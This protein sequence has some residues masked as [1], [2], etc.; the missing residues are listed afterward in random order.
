MPRKPRRS[1]PERFARDFTIL[2]L[3]EALAVGRS[4]SCR[5][6]K[7]VGWTEQVLRNS[8]GEIGRVA[9]AVAS[10]L[11]W[12]VYGAAILDSER[13]RCEKKALAFV[14][15]HRFIL[16]EQVLASNVTEEKTMPLAVTVTLPR[17]SLLRGR[18]KV[19]TVKWATGKHKV[20]IS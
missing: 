3:E 9:K 13:E 16:A 12:F 6:E 7:F 18:G 15:R 1:G 2:V 19:Y 14:R 4:R 20:V 11:G 8:R 5:P 10:K 17:T